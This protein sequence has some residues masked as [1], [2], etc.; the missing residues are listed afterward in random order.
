MRKIDKLYK[1]KAFVQSRIDKL[2]E[3]CL[4][5][6]TE[7]KYIVCIPGSSGNYNVCCDCDKMLSFCDE[8]PQPTANPWLQVQ[9]LD[10]NAVIPWKDNDP[11]GF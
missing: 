4:H 2:Q 7:I 10:A 8:Q 6:K 9:G 11:L 5:P 1:R 3:E